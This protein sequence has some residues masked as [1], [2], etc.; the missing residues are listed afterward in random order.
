M[1]FLNV[2]GF[3]FFFIVLF[4]TLSLASDSAP[5]SSSANEIHAE[6]KKSKLE[7]S[8]SKLISSSS[9]LVGYVK[10]LPERTQRAALCV[11]E[12]CKKT[13]N[14]IRRMMDDVL[15]SYKNSDISKWS[16]ERKIRATLILVGLLAVPWLS[17]KLAA[18]LVVTL[19]KVGV[20]GLVIIFL[21]AIIADLKR[22]YDERKKRR[23]EKKRKQIELHSKQMEELNREKNEETNKTK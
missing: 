10:K 3:F 13:Y 8:E 7:N 12:G 20:F 1:K 19:M 15:R 16:L 6:E 22:K 11:G 23:L 18:V 9:P 17:Y 21:P 14:V 4:S 2:S 5:S